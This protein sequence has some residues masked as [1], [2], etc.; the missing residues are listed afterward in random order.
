[1]SKA[2]PLIIK[3]KRHHTSRPR[4]VHPSGVPSHFAV[5]VPTKGN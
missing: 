5:A 3:R 2:H 1:M 4:A